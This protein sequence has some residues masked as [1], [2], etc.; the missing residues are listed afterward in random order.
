MPHV[1]G[2]DLSLARRRFVDAW[3]EFN[4]R[5][6]KEKYAELFGDFVRVFEAHKDGV[7]HAHVIIECKYSLKRGSMPHRWKPNGN[8]DGATVADWVRD[9]GVNFGTANFPNTESA[10]G[11]HYS[12][13]ARALSAFRNT[14]Q[15]TSQRDSERVRSTCADCVRWRIRAAFWLARGCWRT[16]TTK[17]P[18]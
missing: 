17:A 1:A 15:N 4:R 11:T 13:F 6:L 14:L 10:S 3:N 5:V 8:V 7:L 12:R 9:I 16:T 18:A 2:E